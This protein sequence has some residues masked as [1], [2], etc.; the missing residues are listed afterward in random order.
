MS[1]YL[2]VPLDVGITEL[3]HWNINQGRLLMEAKVKHLS[4]Q[5]SKVN[6]F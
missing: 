4:V 2:H 3:Q 1:K 6:I 5:L